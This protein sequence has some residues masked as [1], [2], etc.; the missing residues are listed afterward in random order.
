MSD[1]NL[2]DKLCKN[3]E[4]SCIKAYKAGQQSMQTEIEFLKAQ[5]S[6][7]RDRNK[8]LETELIGSRNYGD[9]LQKQIDEI[10]SY[11]T[12]LAEYASYAEII[13]AVSH[14][15]PAIREY[16]DKIFAYNRT[17]DIEEEKALRGDSK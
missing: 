11:A 8:A 15:R 10:S 7:Q 13:G 12:E 17:I 4:D 9:G 14:N 16:C 6:L 5:L 1:L 3:L 2:E